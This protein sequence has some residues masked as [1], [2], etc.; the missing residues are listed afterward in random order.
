MPMSSTGM[1]R[2]PLVPTLPHI[3]RRML[4]AALLVMAGAFPA[5]AGTNE[6]PAQVKE[7][8]RVASGD[9]VTITVF[10]QPQLSGEFNVDGSGN[11][12][13]ALIGDV[14]VGNLTVE[15][16]EQAIGTRY[17]AGFLHNPVVNVR[18]SEFR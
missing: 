15:E 7:P 4:A 11:L 14:H 8:Y 10:D 13:L 2:L 17:S 16:A 3:V 5:W 9:R 12:R 6:S 18:V 1:D